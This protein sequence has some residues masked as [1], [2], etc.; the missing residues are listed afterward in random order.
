MPILTHLQHIL[1]KKGLTEAQLQEWFADKGFICQPPDDVKGFKHVYILKYIGEIQVWS[2]PL[3]RHCRGTVLYIDHTNQDVIILKYMLQKGCEI[4]TSL[5]ENW[6]SNSGTLDERQ[7]ETKRQIEQNAKID[8]YLSEKADGMCTSIGFFKEGERRTEIM[9]QIIEHVGG[10]SKAILDQC[11][12]LKLGFFITLSSQNT[13]LIEDVST[14]CYVVTALMGAIGETCPSN[15]LPE[16]SIS[17]DLI[18]RLSIFMQYDSITVESLCAENR[19]SMGIEHQELVFKS[20]KNTIFVLNAV[21]GNDVMPH[22]EFSDLITESGFEEP[23]YWRIKHVQTIID[24]LNAKTDLVWKRMT[25]EEFLQRFKPANKYTGQEIC[26]E[27]FVLYAFAQGEFHYNK[28]KLPLYYILHSGHNCSKMRVEDVFTLAQIGRINPAI[29]ENA[30]RAADF[31]DSLK[32]RLTV[33][34]EKLRDI[35]K[36]DSELFEALNE[37]QKEIVRSALKQHAYERATNVLMSKYNTWQPLSLEIFVE[38]FPEL[39]RT[40]TSAQVLHKIIWQMV[41]QMQPLSNN[42]MENISGMIGQKIEHCIRNFYVAIT[43]TEV[44]ELAKILGIIRF[45]CPESTDYDCAVVVE[46]IADTKKRLD[47]QEVSQI[48]GF[49]SESIDANMICVDG[50]GNIIAT[51]KGAMKETQAIIYYTY[52]LHSQTYPL[53]LKEPLCIDINDRIKAVITFILVHLEKLIGE[54]EYKHQTDARKK[55]FV[56]GQHRTNYV[57]SILHLIR[58]FDTAASRDTHKSLVMKLIQVILAN[59]GDYEYTKR[60]LARKIAEVIPGS[61]QAALWHL[62]RRKEGCQSNVLTELFSRFIQIEK[63]ENYPLTWS[64]IPMNIR[65]TTQLPDELFQEFLKSPYQPTDTFREGFMRICPHGLIGNIF[66]IKSQNVDKL[67]SRVQFYITKDAQRS[68]QWYKM[69]EEF[70]NGSVSDISIDLASDWVSDYYN[71]IRGSIM[72]LV[73]IGCADFRVLFDMDIVTLGLIINKGTNAAPDFLAT[74]GEVIIC[75]E[76]KCI[77]GEPRDNHDYRRAVSQARRQMRVTANLLELTA[78]KGAMIIVYVYEKDGR[79]FH[80]ARGTI[81]DL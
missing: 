71:L 61:E 62:F 41:R 52:H 15:M 65:N 66:P 48:T 8:A 28:I 7:L 39:E 17:D 81:M 64:P 18:K 25:K 40:K 69:R 22:Y 46:T 56:G 63:E 51:S 57:L 68:E 12:R 74:D 3:A 13:L 50:Q 42:Y 26:L 1:F 21:S 31:F 76:I 78:A 16:N 32:N 5:H 37:T 35:L 29:S 72:E 6:R 60:G 77:A 11:D 70:S 10:F 58:E 27:G 14:Q 75:G 49:A 67:P 73:V 43:H 45:G 19:C 9:R 36:I 34:C 2:E 80:E 53:C 20:G 54:E 55:A 33:I 47:M 79:A 38:Q 23:L 44:K 30:R 4:G 59:Q 24:M